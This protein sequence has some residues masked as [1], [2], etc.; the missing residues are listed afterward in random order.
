[1]GMC[2]AW[3]DSCM[4][5]CRGVGARLGGHAPPPVSK[6]SPQ[7]GSSDAG[8]IGAVS[9]PSIIFLS[10]IYTQT[11]EGL[12]KTELRLWQGVGALLQYT[13]RHH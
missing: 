4:P 1:M 9:S 2:Q 13:G 10:S 12:A 8:R 7:N 6:P 3:Q 5:C 11:V